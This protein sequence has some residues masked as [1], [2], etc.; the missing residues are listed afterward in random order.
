MTADS[1]WEMQKAVYDILRADA[2]LIALAGDGA[3]PARTTVYDRT[4]QDSAFPYIVV[5]EATALDWD[6]KSTDGMELTQTIH[7]WSRY[8]G[9]KEVKQI[10]GA[11][12]DAIDGATMSLTGHT[13]IL[14]RFE[15]SETLDDPDGRTRHGIQRFRALTQGD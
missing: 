7:S 12:V 10:M 5:G 3:S 13:L 11:I 6:T 9:A 15:F 1:Q 2:A 14:I 8:S 4:P